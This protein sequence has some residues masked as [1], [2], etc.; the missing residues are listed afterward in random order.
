MT[1]ARILTV[2]GALLT[3]TGVCLS[4]YAITH[5]LEWGGIV[6]ITASMAAYP[7][8]AVALAVR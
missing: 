6:A 8:A 1:R 4:H 3:A 7:A 5:P 2:A